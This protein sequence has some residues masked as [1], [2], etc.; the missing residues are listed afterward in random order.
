MEELP[1]AVQFV[2]VCVC[3]EAADNIPAADDRRHYPNKAWCHTASS[4]FTT[5]DAPSAFIPWAWQCFFQFTFD[6]WRIRAAYMP[7]PIN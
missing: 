1:V 6:A 4:Y 5:Q 3:A 7:L 2:F